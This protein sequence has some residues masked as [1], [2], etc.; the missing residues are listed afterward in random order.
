MQ[1]VGFFRLGAEAAN[2]H[3]VPK[4]RPALQPQAVAVAPAWNGRPR[5]SAG[6]QDFRN[7]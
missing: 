4:P 6:D 7:F 5:N 1:Q 2:G 3:Y